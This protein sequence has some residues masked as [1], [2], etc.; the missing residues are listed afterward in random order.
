MNELL[1]DLHWRGL[2][3][4]STDEA[5]LSAD[6]DAGPITLYIGFDP[7]AASLHVGHLLQ[8]ITLRRFQL[9]GHRAI[10]LV[11][12]A[13]GLIGDPSFKSAERALNEAEVVAE[14]VERLRGQLER[15]LDFEGDNP[16]LLVN[17]LDWTGE[18]SA[19]ELLRDVGKHFSINTMLARES[20]KARLETGISYTEFSYVLLQALDFVELYRRYGCR[21]QVGGSDQWGNI[22]A[23]L[24]LIRRMEG[25]SGHALTTPLLTKADGTKFGKTESGAVW[26]DPAMTSPYAFYQFWFNTD[27]RDVI[28]YLKALS[29]RPRAEIEELAEAVRERPAARE[30]QRAL[31]D[32]L[33]ALV[34]SPA[35]RDAVVAASR[36]LFGRGDLTALDED[37]LEAS[38]AELPRA[39]VHAGADGLPP[40]VD[41][42]A[43]TGL[44]ESKSA[45]RRAVR[46]GGAHVN[47]IRVPSEDH[48]PRPEDLL[49][50]RFLVL[51]RG[52][53]HLAAVEVL[54][55]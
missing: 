6:L 17:N 23:G 11:G 46:D 47:N 34:H 41:L 22:T 28:S 1:E 4:Q 44:V 42:F 24:D 52:K 13:T 8:V 48:V 30:A 43:E 35:E 27:D 7:T 26:L 3:A 31:A 9:A 38:L 14:W 40:V 25:G 29:F 2:I 54:R 15:F 21:L 33:T 18:L 12:G 55:S 50:G 39:T 45:A 5:A 32:E 51:R 16:A 19:I 10:G 53:R 37:L 20:V 49:H 36:A